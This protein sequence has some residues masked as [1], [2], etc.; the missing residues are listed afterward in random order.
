MGLMK[1]IQKMGHD[2]AAIFRGAIVALMS[3]SIL[4]LLA[5]RFIVYLL[6]SAR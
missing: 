3:G 2:E 5:P 1:R 6:Q 4:F